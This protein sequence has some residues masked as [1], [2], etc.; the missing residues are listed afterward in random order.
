MTTLLNDFQESLLLRSPLMAGR[1]QYREEIRR[2]IAD[3]NRR[4]AFYFY[5]EGG[6]GKTRLLEEVELLRKEWSGE[7]FR[8]SSIIDFYHDRFHSSIGLFKEIIDTLDPQNQ[9]FQ[10]FRRILNEFEEKRRQGYFGGPLESLLKELQ[11]HFREE[12]KSI[13]DQHRLV[14]CFDTLERVQH[15]IET[16]WQDFQAQDVDITVKS[17]FLKQAVL[18]PNT[19]ILLAGRPSPKLQSE[20]MHGFTQ[21]GWIC[22]ESKID[23]L[24]LEEVQEYLDIKAQQYL[25]LMEA[26]TS[27]PQTRDWLVQKSDCLP[28]RLDMAIDLLIHDERELPSEYEPID[29]YL[30]ERLR[31][32]PNKFGEMIYHLMHA[33]KGL[34]IDL[35]KYLVKD[36]WNQAEIQSIFAKMPG[37]AIVKA[38]PEI[39]GTRQLFLHDELYNLW[40]KYCRADP[41]ESRAYARIADYYRNQLGEA[42][43]GKRES[44]MLAS[45][46][47]ELQANPRAGYERY[48][49]YYA[50]WDRED[51]RSYTMDFG[52]RLSDEA[53]GF[54]NRYTNPQSEF[55]DERIATS[56]ISRAT[57]ERALRAH[58]VTLHVERGAHQ[59]AR[60]MAEE[61]RDSKDPVFDLDRIDDPPYKA[62]LL[63]ALGEAMLYT[64]APD[65]EA[66]LVL[67]QAKRLL[68][69]GSRKE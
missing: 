15:E 49:S 2:A 59:K 31:T 17:W 12:Y 11:H 40:D 54:I 19:V 61:L 63:T 32:L 67:E 13:A 43:S 36:R 57:F 39:N 22:R 30:V 29:E 42:P 47:Y 44:L 6:I 66:R 68:E 34:D 64:G 26:M 51:P 37:F 7:K 20:L 41:D 38:P 58:V 9:Q 24:S 8:S 56:G 28:I 16:V 46:Y 35:L 52:M 45:L 62:S 5:G 33:R 25:K 23:R 4:Y 1:K 10:E 53:L 14:L 60:A 48:Y 69:K 27:Q 55:R 18:F 21:A 50:R 3:E 65:K